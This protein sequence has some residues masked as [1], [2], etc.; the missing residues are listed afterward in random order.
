MSGLDQITEKIIEDARQTAQE[1]RA[2]AEKKAGT[3]RKELLKQA[4]DQQKAMIG[5]AK[6]KAQM[7]RETAAVSAR[8]QGQQI[9]LSAR[10][11]IIDDIMCQIMERLNGLNDTAYFD[12]LLRLFERYALPREG[13]LQISQADY[14]RMPGDFE[15]TLN[16]TLRQKGGGIKIEAS[17][18]QDIGG[19]FILSY[20]GVEENCT[21]KALIAANQDAIRDKI[22]ERL[23]HSNE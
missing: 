20:G 17:P 5:E 1:A 19:G 14:K 11:G 6:K 10:Q 8:Q 4:M 15:K 21:F 22:C 16:Q 12:L 13:V 9:L 3:A 18:K 7:I 2:Y 23:F